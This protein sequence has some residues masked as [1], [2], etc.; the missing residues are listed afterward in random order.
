M[1]KKL[2]KAESQID[3]FKDAARDLE[4]DEDEKSF[5][6]KLRRIAKPQPKKEKPAD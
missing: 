2:D 4:C 5:Q 3:K 1:T 6:D